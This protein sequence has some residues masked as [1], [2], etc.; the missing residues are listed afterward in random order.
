M[1]MWSNQLIPSWKALEWIFEDVGQSRQVST[2][3]SQ[4]HDKVYRCICAGWSREPPLN[5]RN[6]RGVH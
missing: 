4:S 1:R 6:A 2:D 3:P 5:V